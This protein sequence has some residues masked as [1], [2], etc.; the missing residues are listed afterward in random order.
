MYVLI[1]LRVG[2]LLR[3]GYSGLLYQQSCKELLGADVW[4]VWVSRGHQLVVVLSLLRRVYVEMASIWDTP[5]LVG[6]IRNLQRKEGRA[7]VKTV[8]FCL[9]N[10]RI[11]F[12]VYHLSM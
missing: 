6:Q 11:F 7:S 12:S 9:Q 2:M 1:A 10:T 8:Q 3:V 5:A 4:P